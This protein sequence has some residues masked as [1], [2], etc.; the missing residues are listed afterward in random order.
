MASIFQGEPETYS[1]TGV[2]RGR[3][4]NEHELTCCS[5]QEMVASSSRIPVTILLW[6]N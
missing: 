6:E 3:I 1:M 2:E 5:S 4:E